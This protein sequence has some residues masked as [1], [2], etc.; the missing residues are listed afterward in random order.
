MKRGEGLDAIEM[1]ESKDNSQKLFLDGSAAERA[2]SG[3]SGALACRSMQ[4]DI[5]HRAPIDF[6]G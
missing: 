6:N 4:N 5:F 1:R 3:P 2:A